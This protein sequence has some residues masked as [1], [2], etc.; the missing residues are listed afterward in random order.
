M[1]KV[2]SSIKKIHLELTNNEAL[3]L[4][5]FLMRYRDKG[6]LKIKHEAED[7]LIYDLCAMLESNVPQLLESN[8]L[9]LLNKAREVVISN[10][11]NE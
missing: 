2:N 9:E 7:I 8:Y 1:D 3:V 4:V 10:I 11:E 6:E 5:H